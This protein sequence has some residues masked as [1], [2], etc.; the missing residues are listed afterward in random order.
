[1]F[2]MDDPLDTTS[3]AQLNENYLPSRLQVLQ[4]LFYYI[5]ES[6]KKITVEDASKLIAR[7]LEEIWL[8][9]KVKI[10]TMYVTVPKIL[11]LYQD[12]RAYQKSRNPTGTDF[13]KNRNEVFDI[14][15]SDLKTSFPANEKF[16][17]LSLPVFTIAE[18]IEKLQLCQQSGNFYF[19]IKKKTFTLKNN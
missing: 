4:H 9:T 17:L 10:Q 2:N 6:T 3:L 16:S 12:F 11:K 18:R 13:F 8:Q 5:R 19:I 1:M 14:S 15:H 7:R